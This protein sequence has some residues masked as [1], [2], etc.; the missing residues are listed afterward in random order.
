ML[1]PREGPLGL[2]VADLGA[3]FARSANA[4]SL[5][6]RRGDAARPAGITHRKSEAG[7][8]AAL[9]VQVAVEA[10]IDQLVMIEAEGRAQA[11]QQ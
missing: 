1:V 4:Q 10:A 11:F 9:A 5:A 3:H 8:A 7:R 6:T 2:S